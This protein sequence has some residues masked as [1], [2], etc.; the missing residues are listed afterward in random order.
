VQQTPPLVAAVLPP[1]P[2]RRAQIPLD[3]TATAAHLRRNGG[4]RPAL[5]VQGPHGVIRCLPAGGGVYAVV[6]VPR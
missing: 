1:G 5:A 4:D 6:M 3:G 2:R